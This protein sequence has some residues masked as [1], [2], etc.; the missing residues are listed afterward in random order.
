MRLTTLY[1]VFALSLGQGLSLQ[2]KA[3]NPSI[4][5]PP[6]FT[7]VSEIIL[8]V[9]DLEASMKRQWEEFGIGPWQIWTFDAQSTRGLTMHGEPSDAAFRVAYT[10]IGDTYW[11]LVQPLDDRSTYYETLQERGE[12]VH[13]IVFQVADFE[14]AAGRLEALGY[15]SYN[16]A[17]W[18]AVEFINFDTRRTLSVIAEIYRVAPGEAFP[19]PEAT[20]PPEM[21]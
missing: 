7:G 3:Q 18:G 16:A 5:E 12:G 2:A 8:V 19:P 15:E 9:R 13:N 10:Q 14:D 17:Q 6:L 21:P 11:E 20:Y 4:T 1:A